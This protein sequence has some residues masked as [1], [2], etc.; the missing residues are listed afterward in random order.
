MNENIPYLMEMGIPFD[1]ASDALK[2]F[3]GNLEDAVNFIFSNDIISTPMSSNEQNT[4]VNNPNPNPNYLQLNDENSQLK[5]GDLSHLI[6]NNNNNNN[7]N[8]HISNQFLSSSLSSSSSPSSSSSSSSSSSTTSI[9]DNLPD[10]N[11]MKKPIFKTDPLNPTIIL[12][13]PPNSLIENYLALFAYC[14]SR[15]V[16]KWFLIPDFRDLNYN[17]NWF[18]GL[19]LNEPSF[20]LVT[21]DNT[22]N[23]TNVEDHNNDSTN[24]NDKNSQPVTLWQLQKLIS[25]INDPNSNRAYISASIFRLVFDHQLKLKLQSTDRLNEILPSFLRSILIDL[26]L[27]PTIDKES[28]N[29]MFISRASYRQNQTDSEHETYVM[30][31]HFPP[32]EFDTNLYK[33]FNALLY[34]ELEEEEEEEETS[35]EYSENLLKTI[36]P[37]FTIIF[38]EM[39]DMTDDEIAVPNGVDI[40]FEF[41][42]QLY[43]MTVKNQL[44]KHIMNKRRN[45]N[46]RL[47]QCLSEIQTLK[48]FQGKDI[49][50]ILNSSI[51]YMEHDNGDPNHIHLLNSIKEAITSRLESLKAEHEDL[52]NKLQKEWNISHPEYYIIE[53]AKKMGLIDEPLLLVMVTISP[54]FYFIR[55]KNNMDQWSLIQSSTNGTDFQII[56]NITEDKVKE[57]I[58]KYT[59]RPNQTPIMFNYCKKDYIDSDENILKWIHANEGCNKFMKSDED[60]FVNE[61]VERIQ[62]E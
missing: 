60:Y 26:E 35:K 46:S 25:T 4:L 10:Y 29:D 18:K 62:Q 28:V 43:T 51:K 34:P 52:R 58:S 21:N 8:E 6:N 53:S 45:A 17:S 27:C 48:S 55:D 5:P 7:T 19:E 56:N 22:N 61:S 12:S 39:D 1:V 3:N 38:N 30:L 20:K 41:Y 50:T 32:E 24:N 16:P 31:L 11:I 40:P 2:R 36:S 57:T 47:K 59:S 14:I 13:L 44:I 15:F 23:G 42:P 37:F 33:M 54:Y 9:N 49:L